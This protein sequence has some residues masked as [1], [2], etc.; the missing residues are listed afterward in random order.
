M[1]LYGDVLIVD[2]DPIVR[3]VLRGYFEALPVKS[4]Q[5]AADG[6]AAANVVRTF[7]GS[8]DLIVTD[9]SM[10][11]EDGIQLLRRLH[12]QGFRGDVVIASGRDVSIIETAQSLANGHSLKVRGCI[13]K[14][15]TKSKMDQVFLADNTSKTPVKQPDVFSADT[16]SRLY[17]EQGI[18]PYF[19]PKIAVR[20][21]KIVGVEALVRG[22]HEEFGHLGAFPLITAARCHNMM[23]ELTDIMA[24]KALKQLSIWQGQGIALDLALNVDPAQLC[25]LD[26]PDRLSKLVGEVGVRSSQIIVEVT[27]ESFSSDILKV[28]DVLTRLR[29][30][31]FRTSSDDFGTGRS[32]IDTLESLPFTE[33]KIDQSFVFKALTHSFADVAIQTVVKL[34]KVSGL[35]LVAEGVETQE[36]LQYLVDLKVNVVQGYLFARPMPAA[37]FEKWY[38][39]NEGYAPARLFKTERISATLPFA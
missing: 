34:A 26:L 11:D 20:T 39:D 25:E 17:K 37:E 15:L 21:G 23:G 1:T 9:L 38:R 10:P 12:D 14:P 33:L 36:Q 8:F 30:K 7:S 16:L 13:S 32:N 22:E 2:D 18:V 31:G 6:A 3:A 27:E 28:M 29:M 5:A 4:V 24:R 35:D 19:Q